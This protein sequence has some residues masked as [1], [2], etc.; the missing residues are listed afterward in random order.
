LRAFYT[1]AAHKLEHPLR[2]FTS[3]AVD[4][5]A[6]SF[7]ETIDQQ[8]YTCYACAIVSDHIHLLIRKH[9]HFAEDMIANL[10]IATRLRVRDR[11][12]FEFNH[13]VWGGPGWKVFLH[14]PDDIRRT[15]KYIN[16]NPIKLH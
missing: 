14:S 13:P 15:I 7:A 10:Q 12:F 1:V 11:N 6:E 5:I 16:D 9:K 8:R 4:C 3:C 2:D